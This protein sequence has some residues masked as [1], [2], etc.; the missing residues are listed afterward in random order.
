MLSSRGLSA[1]DIA[2]IYAAANRGQGLDAASE[3]LPGLKSSAVLMP[4]QRAAVLWM[5]AR[6]GAEDAR[7]LQQAHGEALDSAAIGGV[8]ADEPGLGKSL[9]TLALLVAGR[10]QAQGLPSLIV[11]P[12]PVIAA[13]WKGEVERFVSEGVR[14]MQYHGPPSPYSEEEAA[15]LVEDLQTSEIV[16]TDLGVLK[17]EYHYLN[18][19]YVHAHTYLPPPLPTRSRN[20]FTTSRWPAASHKHL[21]LT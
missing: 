7:Q 6:E 5:L 19:N 20:M 8:L 15:Q 10:S 2:D 16:L 14:V 1:A 12:T 13:Q 21:T 9:T 18:G 17:R 3:A 4:H 11:S